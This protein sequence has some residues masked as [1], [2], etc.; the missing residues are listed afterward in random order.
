MAAGP[1]SAATLWTVNKDNMIVEEQE[2][3]QLVFH[4]QSGDTHILNFLSAGVVEVLEQGGPATFQTI[5]DTVR[6]KFELDVGECPLSLIKA[7]V[8]ELDDVALVYPQ[9]EGCV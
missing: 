7:T 2:D 5:A 4:R 6:D 8:L 9:E 1:Y 3:V